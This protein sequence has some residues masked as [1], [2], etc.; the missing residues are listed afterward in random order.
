VGRA[1]PRFAPFERDVGAG[2]ANDN[3]GAGGAENKLAKHL[4]SPISTHEPRASGSPARLAL[5]HARLGGARDGPARTA[6]RAATK[7]KLDGATDRESARTS[8][9]LGGA[10]GATA[11]VAEMQQAQQW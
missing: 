4:R 3:D 10:G 8:T 2:G 6:P 11:G 5:V 7:A 1:H 9:D